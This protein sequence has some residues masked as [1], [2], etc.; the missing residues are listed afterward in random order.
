M[1]KFLISAACLAV[2][3]HGGPQEAMMRIQR[4]RSK[5]NNDVACWGLQNTIQYNVQLYKAVGE[6]KDF[7]SPRLA[8]T[9]PANPFALLQTKPFQTLP[10]SIDRASLKRWNKIFSELLRSKRQAEEGLIETDEADVEEFLANYEDFKGSVTSMLANLTCV[11]SKMG[12]LDPNFQINMDFYDNQI[13][14]NNNLKET[15]AGE[16]PEWR[17]ILT[18]GFND[19]YQI[20]QTFPEQALERD[21]LT[22]VFGRHML[23]FKC[24]KKVERE[25]CAAAQLHQWLELWYGKDDGSVDWTQF[26][27]PKNK[28]ER[29]VVSM[30]TQYDSASDEE[31]FIGDFFSGRDED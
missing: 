16:D 22:K 18:S 17:Q 5:F 28:Y 19:C 20:A 13:W 6:C 1:L 10:Q 23:F 26:W 15:L 21:P 11:L 4:D 7:G 31:K 14:E 12:A 25:S 27:L 24:A 30:M 9:K 3:T 8:L 29:A 2:A